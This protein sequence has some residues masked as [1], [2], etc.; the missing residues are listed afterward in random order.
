MADSS[1]NVLT[2]RPPAGLVTPNPSGNGNVFCLFTGDWLSLQ[3]FVVKALALPLSTGDFTG[4]YGA[5]ADMGEVESVLSA[6]RQVTQLASRFGDPMT[7][8]KEISTNPAYTQGTTPPEDIYGHIVWFASRLY[9][10]AMSF[11]GTLGS[12]MELLNPAN[13]TPEERA[14]NLKMVLTGD[15]GLQ[16][17]AVDM[18]AQTNV[19]LKKLTQFDV[20]LEPANRTL[21]SYMSNSAKFY[22]DAVAAKEDDERQV[23]TLQSEANDAYKKWQNLT[24]MATTMSV[25]LMVVTAG[26]S[27]PVSIGLGV[28]LGVEAQKALDDYNRYMKEMGEKQEDDQ[29]K[30]RLIADL[31]GFNSAI[32][33]VAG[34]SKEFITRLQTVESIW[35]SIGNNLGYIA[36]T[37]TVE[38]LSSYPWINEAM[39]LN[40]ATKDWQAIRDAV[41]V[42]TQQSLVTFD[43]SV[44]WGKPIPRSKAA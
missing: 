4:M 40:T 9:Q 41:E 26:L 44:E 42:F 31:Q 3:S 43:K 10:T 7:L 22:Q 37:F 32:D 13:G 29:K 20:D 33:D 18:Q 5:F 16:S 27:L 19:L 36:T 38:N 34:A 28:G 24:I 30:I 12:F 15:G 8:I 2:L 14:A 23:V 1:N 39:Q 17:T 21:Q 6:M 11:Q 35:L 25:G